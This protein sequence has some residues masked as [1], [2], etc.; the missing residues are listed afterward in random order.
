VHRAAVLRV[1]VTDHGTACQRTRLRTLENGLEPSGRSVDEQFFAG[2]VL[3]IDTG[4]DKLLIIDIKSSPD[5][6]RQAP[7]TMR[8]DATCRILHTNTSRCSLQTDGRE[9]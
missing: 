9:E 2:W 8:G 7:S 3:I 4:L 6:D 1:R 5:Q